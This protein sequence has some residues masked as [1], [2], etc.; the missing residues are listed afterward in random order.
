[1][2]RPRFATPTARAFRLCRGSIAALLGAGTI[3]AGTPAMAEPA[4]A[5]WSVTDL[6]TLGGSGGS[7]AYAINNLGQV[8]G[9]ASP[10]TGVEHA[11]LYSGGALADIGGGLVA[12]G[13]GLNDAGMVTGIADGLNGY[14][15]AFLYRNGSLSNLAPF[16]SSYSIGAGVNAAGQVALTFTPAGIGTQRAALYS[17]G[18]L[19]DLGT[20]G[21]PNSGANAI[22]AAGQ[23]T[24][25][26]DRSLEL[27]SSTMPR[28]AFLY[29]DGV[30]TDLGSL[31]GS[32]SE[33]FGINASGQVTGAS[34]SA[35]ASLGT[36]AFVVSNGRMIDLGTLGGSDS[37]GRA[38]NAT[39]QITGSSSV[40]GSAES[41]AFLY[42]ADRMLDLNNLNGVAGSGWMLS[43]GN[44]IN[45]HGQIVGGGVNSA[46][47]GRA[48][49]LA[50][51]TTVWEASGNG[52]WADA[53][54]WSYGLDP[55]LNTRVVIDPA[56]SLSVLGP[57]GNVTVRSLTIGGEATGNNGLA[58][59]VLNGGAITLPGLAIVTD[60]GVLTGDGVIKG[61]VRNH[62]DIVATNIAVTGD[63][64]NLG[65]IRITRL[66]VQGDFANQ[67]TVTG[68]GVL[69]ARLSN[70]AT[71]LLRLDA[72]Q[73]LSITGGTH[74]NSG[75]IE[76]RQ[77]SELQFAG[78]FTN[79]GVGQVLVDGSIVRF[80]G[81][82]GN[83]AGGRIVL[84][85]GTAYFNGGLDNSGQV[86]V[87]FG[88]AEI[89]GS[90]TTLAGGRLI[91]SGNSNT[92]FHDTVDVKSGG[93][94]RVSAGS[95]AVFFGPVLQRTGALFTG[96]GSKFYEGGL[97]IGSSPG[98]GVDAGD[99][100]F[101]GGNVYT[102]E[103]A[104]LAA[105]TGFDKYIVAGKLGFGG[106]LK[107]VVLDGFQARAGYRFDL[108]DWGSSSGSFGDIDTSA[109][110][111]GPGLVWDF[112]QLYGNG[113]I[114]VSAVPEPQAWALGLAGLGVLARRTRRVPTP[115]Q[116]H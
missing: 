95:T 20:L 51:D 45:D 65:N 14:P 28:R 41:H 26:A 16:G 29:R 35:D 80:A 32:Y 59:L 5:H 55:N 56:R 15:N 53:A 112:S 96:S 24:G 73:A 11:F 61:S 37:T 34:S 18:Q 98:L 111:L 97:A 64:N 52:S 94:L 25:Y 9:G 17:A 104:G 6:G 91:L 49:L 116:R 93:E 76:L 105:G 89:F 102:A 12:S 19:I 109:A 115:A 86:Q 54:N 10:V 85:H 2:S 66:S 101:G 92:S 99:V 43:S 108:F 83:D 107:L 100:G 81:P 57:A 58:T 90:V 1:M 103:I 75:R 46:G 77:G 72:G 50:L 82:V 3:C 39:G 106:T 7:V 38:I 78:N 62:G 33:G 23:I 67:G 68:H 4:V 114:G 74:A 40:A 87:G 22:N 48:F 13:R 110:G 36:H 44:G 88:G 70:G 113:E 79:Q 27:R 63:L 8:T 47:Q 60:K 31:G 69:N 71:G 30:M 84:N 21:G 42:T